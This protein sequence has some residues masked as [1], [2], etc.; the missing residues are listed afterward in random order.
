MRF[1][2][3]LFTTRMILKAWPRQLSEFRELLR[4]YPGTLRE[5]QEWPFHSESI[6]PEIGVV[7]VKFP[8]PLKVK[9]STENGGKSQKIGR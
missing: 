8:G 1:Q 2:T 4:E 5:L 3:F 9:I 6:S 7:G